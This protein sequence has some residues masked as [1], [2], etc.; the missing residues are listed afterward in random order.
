MLATI[1]DNGLCP[2]PRCLMLKAH[3]DRMGWILDSAFRISGIRQYLHTKVQAARDLVYQLGH[4]VAGARVDALL[5]SSSS[6]P[7]IVSKL[8]TRA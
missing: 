3:L 2:C 8:L 4:A 5:K 1:R 7:T 6:V